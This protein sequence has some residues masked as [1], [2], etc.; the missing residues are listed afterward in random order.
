[1]NHP[2]PRLLNLPRLAAIGAIMLLSGCLT[3]EEH[4]TF[5][6]DGSGT[7]EYVMD[8]SEI[9]SMMDALGSSDQGEGGGDRKS[10]V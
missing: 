8:M 9:G 6:K 5:K 2:V 3:I 1:M 4:Y 7:M 10:T